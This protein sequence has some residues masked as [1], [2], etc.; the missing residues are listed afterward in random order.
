MARP[1]RA[2][3]AKVSSALDR[4]QPIGKVGSSYFGVTEAS[5]SQVAINDAFQATIVR[6]PSRII[7]GPPK[8]SAAATL[9]PSASINTFGGHS[10]ADMAGTIQNTPSAMSAADRR[11]PDVLLRVRIPMLDSGPVTSTVKVPSNMYLADVLELICRKRKEPHL[12]QPKDWVLMVA[13]KDIVVPLDRTVEGLQGVHQL[14]LARRADVADLIE[15]ESR[16]ANPAASIFKR[17]SE[18]PQPKYI[19]AADVTSSY[20]VRRVSGAPGPR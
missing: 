6:R 2:A 15:P 4:S 5:S 3:L 19:S 1:G 12:S 13:D 9:A 14:G 20:R 18:V 16:S 10:L 17:L 8:T 11:A 7:A